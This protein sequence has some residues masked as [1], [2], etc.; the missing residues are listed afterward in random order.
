MCILFLSFWLMVAHNTSIFSEE[1]Q[2]AHL[3]PQKP[4]KLASLLPIRY[5]ITHKFS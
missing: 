2:D 3:L 5:S 4:K 1:Q